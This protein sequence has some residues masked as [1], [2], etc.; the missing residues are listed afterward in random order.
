MGLG[1][2]VGCYG[3]VLPTQKNTEILVKLKEEIEAK[4]KMEIPLYLE[5]ILLLQSC[6]RKSLFPKVFLILG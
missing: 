3:G 2:N 1:S 5:V 6:L 4:Y